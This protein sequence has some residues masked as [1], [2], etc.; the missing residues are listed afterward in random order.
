MPTVIERQVRAF[1]ESVAEIDRRSAAGKAV[2]ELVHAGTS[3]GRAI[4][5]LIK[6]LQSDSPFETEDREACINA[7]REMLTSMTQ[8]RRLLHAAEAQGVIVKGEDEYAEAMFEIRE[9]MASLLESAKSAAAVAANEPVESAEQF[10]Q[11]AATHPPKRSW[12]EED[13]RGVRGLDPK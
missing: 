3:L 9:L 8:G 12:F 7:C 4:V 1:G 6:R 5:Q 11:W 13:F 2:Q 10:A